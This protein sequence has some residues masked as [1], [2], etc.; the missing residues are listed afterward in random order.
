MGLADFYNFALRLQHLLQA[1][2]ALTHFLPNSAAHLWHL[3]QNK[4]KRNKKIKKKN[5][6][7]KNNLWHLHLAP[8][9]IRVDPCLALG[10]CRV[11]VPL[12]Y[13]AIIVTITIIIIITISSIT[14]IVT[15]TIIISRVVLEAMGNTMVYH[16]MLQYSTLQQ[17]YRTIVV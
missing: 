1:I 4:I 16:S 17:L 12:K 2:G 5:Q 7:K 8:Y 10:R 15:I 13:P 11:P 9:E 14:I 6:Q 3:H